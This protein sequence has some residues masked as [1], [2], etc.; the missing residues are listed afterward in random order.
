MSG[1]N[2][3]FGIIGLLGSLIIIWNSTMSMIKNREIQGFLPFFIIGIMLILYSILSLLDHLLFY[4]GF[5]L[6]IIIF[7]DLIW[8]F[9]EIRRV[10]KNDI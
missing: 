2:I 3:Y 6:D 10:N 5:Y 1:T 8:I 9:V 4:Q 7:I